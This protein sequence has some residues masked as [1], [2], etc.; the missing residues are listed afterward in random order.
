MPEMPP[1]VHAYLQTLVRH[2]RAVAYLLADPRGRLVDA[3]GDLAAYGL[4]ALPRGADLGEE[5]VFLAGLLPLEGTTLVLS[6]VSTDADRAADLHLFPGEGGDWVV[7][8]DATAAAR[9]QRVV[10]QRN[11]ETGLQYERLT[12]EVQKKE[13][14][15]HCIVHDLAGP[16]TGIRGAYALLASEALSAEG[17]ELLE[18]GERQV[19]R[20]EKLIQG[21]LQ[22]F[23]AEMDPLDASSLDPAHAPDA[24]DCARAVVDGLAPAFVVNRVTL[25]LDPPPDRSRTWLVVGDRSRLERVI[26]NLVENTLRYSPPH[27]TVSVGLAQDHAGVLVTVDDEGP[28][29]PAEAAG[30]LFHKFAQGAGR[31]G[32]IGLGLYFCRITVERWG[33]TIGHSPRSG[34]G[35]RFW[36]RLPQPTA[37]VVA[38]DDRE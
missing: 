2:E 24:A 6:S 7:L 29:V 15:L 10:Q 36:F 27:S 9:Q 12:K 35:S 25:R 26:S 13:I 16:L 32:K 19:V 17:R 21:I 22:V 37:T 34:G 4:D 28:G 20:Q 8:L 1:A 5:V 23:A 38:P 11:L 3:G 33:G 18:L 30:T 14:L 31:R